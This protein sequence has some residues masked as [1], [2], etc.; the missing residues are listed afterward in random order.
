KVKQAQRAV[1]EAE[2]QADEALAAVE[3]III[4]GVPAGGEDDF[5]TLRTHSEPPT[6]DFTPRDHLE[7]G[8]KLGAIDMER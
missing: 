1:T 6:F 8:E 4:D 5:V 7:L 3:N 2:Q